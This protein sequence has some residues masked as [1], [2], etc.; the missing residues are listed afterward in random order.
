MA[1]GTR[2]HAP[3]LAA[4]SYP[5]PEGRPLT[6]DHT[7]MPKA[8]PSAIWCRFSSVLETERRCGGR[9]QMWGCGQFGAWPGMGRGQRWVVVRC[10]GVARC[11]G[12]GQMWGRGQMW[13]WPDWGRGHHSARLHTRS[14]EAP[15][16]PAGLGPTRLPRTS[17]VRRVLHCLTFLGPPESQEPG[18]EGHGAGSGG[19]QG[20]RASP[21]PPS[22]LAQAGSWEGRGSQTPP[23]SP[24]DPPGSLSCLS[25]GTSWTALSQSRLPLSGGASLFL[26]CM[27][28]TEPLTQDLGTHL[29]GP[30]QGSLTPSSVPWKFS[31]TTNQGSTSMASTPL[32]GRGGRGVSRP[33]PKHLSG[34]CEQGSPAPLSMA[35]DAAEAPHRPRKARRER[36][37]RESGGALLPE[38]MWRRVLKDG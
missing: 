32:P 7:P 2:P 25:G 20:S 21:T 6:L 29:Q 37:A 11:G 22:Q 18:R 15:G 12:W 36:E 3:F 10:G 9:G 19:Q 38:E 31:L 17:P 8:L 26:I 28:G 16:A 27:M 14:Q 24:A 5:T 4:H 35:G 34:F 23:W 30:A 33:R 1:L 13:V